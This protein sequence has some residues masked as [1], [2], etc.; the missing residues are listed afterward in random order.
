MAIPIYQ[1]IINSLSA[2]IKRGKFKAGDKL[3]SEKELMN[4]F[5]TSRITVTR[6][7]REMESMNLIYKLKGKGSFVSS[8]E[9]KT[10]PLTKIISLV[11]PHKEDFFSGGY[12]YSR[13]ISKNCRKHGFLCSIH[14]SEN[15]SR[16]EKQILE[17]IEEHNVNGAIIYPISDSNIDTLS[18]MTIGGLPIV[19]IDRRLRELDLPSVTSDNFNGAFEVVSHLTEAGHKRIAFV[20]AMDSDVVTLRYQ[21]YCRALTRAKIAIDPEIAVTRFSTMVEGEQAVLSPDEAA[22]ILELLRKKGVTAVFCVND[23]S[24]YILLQAAD[25]MGIAIPGQLSV[26]GFDNMKY[27]SNIDRELTTV[28]QDFKAIATN[29]VSILMD[30]IKNGLPDEPENLVIPT[31]FLKGNTVSEL[32]LS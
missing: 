3:P 30:I 23:L 21:G 28:A 4:I 25:R 15:S 22:R 27:F 6:A 14:Y 18:R 24:A 7:L 1:K 5:S 19:L 2:D 9:A 32:K 10:T 26:A 20:G 12:Q 17:E 13:Q 31:T 29:S 11:L 16:R 8:G